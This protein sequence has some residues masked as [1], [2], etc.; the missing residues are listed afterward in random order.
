MIW[1]WARFWYNDAM[2]IG[3]ARVSTDDQTLDAQV[4]ALTA[5]GAERIFQE[6]R[7]GKNRDRPE[8][9]ELLKQLRKGD[10]VIV[11]KY[12]R[13]ARSLRDL[14]EIVEAIRERG[15]GFRS[16]GEDIDTTTPAG[17]LIF[18]VFGSIAEFERERIVERTKEGLAAAKKRGRT[19]GRPKALSVE[20]RAEVCRMRD[21]DER[22][23]TE[24]A[25]LFGVS[26]QT[27]MRA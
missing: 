12:D 14:I 10:V 7:T 9:S 18:H 22:S 13:L 16:L 23:V 1:F 27:I 20:Q 21:E 4:D 24:I 25:R 3:Y 19:G 5:A 11:S 17:R 8:L 15:A 2:K 26:R 6:K